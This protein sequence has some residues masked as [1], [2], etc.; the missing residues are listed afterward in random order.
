[1]SSFGALAG[2][3]R[4]GNASFSAVGR[5]VFWWVMPG[6]NAVN[7]KETGLYFYLKYDDKYG[8]NTNIDFGFAARCVREIGNVKPQPCP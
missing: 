1:M 4:N 8:Y 3:C 5:E 2:G 7:E 6:S